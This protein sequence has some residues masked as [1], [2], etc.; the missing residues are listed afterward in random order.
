MILTERDN[1]I[2]RLL[3]QQDFCFYKDIANKFFSS[4]PSASLRFKKLKEKGII[5]LEPIYSSQFNK[6]MDKSS[7]LFIGGNKKVISLNNKYKI[8]KR[9]LS[10]WKIKHQLLLFSV[11]ERLEKL[12]GVPAYFDSH[13]ADLK[14]TLYDRSNEP[15][16][17]LFLKGEDFK[18]AIELELHVK[19]KKRYY[20]KNL[21]TIDHQALRMFFMLFLMLIK[22]RG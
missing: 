14:Y 8:V 6:I 22:S 21:L 11:K 3:Q 1:R 19:S 13:I 4:E 18:L 20:L 15:L 2:I 5:S 17:D 16:P 7:L 9:K 10:Y 12:L